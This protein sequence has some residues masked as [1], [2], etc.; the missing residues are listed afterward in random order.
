MLMLEILLNGALI[1]LVNTLLKTLFTLS[2][3]KHY[4]YIF[5]LSLQDLAYYNSV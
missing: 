4:I 5:R 1:E 2:A 3:G